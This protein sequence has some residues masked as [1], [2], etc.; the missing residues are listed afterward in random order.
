LLSH[1]KAKL[2]VSVLAGHPRGSFLFFRR[3]DHISAALP[4]IDQFLKDMSVN[5]QAQKQQKK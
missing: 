4:L 3:F 2:I 1:Q 5:T